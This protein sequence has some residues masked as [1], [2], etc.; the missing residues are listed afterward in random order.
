MT[1]PRCSFC[2]KS[3]AEVQRLI[4]GADNA[5]ICDEC[6][7]LGAEILSEEGVTGAPARGKTTKQRDAA[8]I[9]SPKAIV[10]HL[11]QYV[12]GQNQAKKVLAVAVYNHY[13][14]VFGKPSDK[15]GEA[16]VTPES[17]VEL[18]KSNVLLIGSTGSGKT[19]LA[20]TMAKLL[21]VPLTI[22]D[23]TTLTEAGYVGEDVETI[24][25]GLLQAADWDVER[26]A[27][28]IVYVDEIDKIA[29][30]GGDNPSITRDVSGEGVQQALLKIIEGTTAN[31]PPN[32]GRKH[33]QQDFIQLDTRNILF[34]CGGA[35]SHLDEIIRRRLQRRSGL[36]FVAGE[37]QLVPSRQVTP[38]FAEENGASPLPENLSDRQ[39]E[40]QIRRMERESREESQLLHQVVP[41]D[42]LAFG[43]I[44]EF[45][46]RLPVFVS[47]DALDRRTLVRILTEPKNSI[48]R[49]FQRLFAM[50]KVELHFESDALD[51]IA[52]E[53]FLRK[54]GARGLRSI[55]EEGL[56][57][58]MFEI[59]SRDDVIRCVVTKEVFTEDKLPNLFGRQGQPITLEKD[60]RSAA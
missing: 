45:I 3:K 54:T 36:G 28:G 9:P 26:A 42:L 23:A 27:Y 7:L 60:F 53:A 6:V 21:D 13:K 58:I 17:D 50:D 34:I 51:A 59:P 39:R 18:T 43:L 14:R 16:Q 5:Y 35:F 56:L 12:I 47:L 4:E 20:Q 40:L 57:D 44:P 22:A 19:L 29:R 25:V 31:V 46:G 48:V 55:V 15:P 8:T 38:T 37:E 1:E 30:K 49:Q 2:G 33:P 11:N 10:A 32:T 41:D 24:L 52:T